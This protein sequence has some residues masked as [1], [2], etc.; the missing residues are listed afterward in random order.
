[1]EYA[2]VDFDEQLGP[3]GGVLVTITGGTGKWENASGHLALSGYFHTDQGTG[4]WD[5][6]GEVCTP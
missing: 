5:Y 4:E 3:N 6:Q 1:M 2:A